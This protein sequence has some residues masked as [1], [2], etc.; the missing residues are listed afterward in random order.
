MA[1]LLASRL[2]ASRRDRRTLRW[3]GATVAA[4]VVIGV[5]VM[6]ADAVLAEIGREGGKV[7]AD[8]RARGERVWFDGGWGFQWYAMQ[9]GGTPLAYTAP[10]PVAGDVV[11]AGLT[12]RLVG[13]FYPRKTLLDR[14]VFGTP[15]GRV[16]SEGAGYYGNRAGPLPWVWGTKEIGRIETWRIDAPMRAR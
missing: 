2:D 5:L 10:L 9:A 12:A 11:V 7:V 16:L 13:E 14:R 3:I 4:C 8:R 1:L 6:R 15:G